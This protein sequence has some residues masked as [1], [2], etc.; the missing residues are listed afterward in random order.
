MRRIQKVKKIK[1]IKRR[2]PPRTKFTVGTSKAE[3]RFGEFLESIGLPIDKQFRIAYKFYDFRIKGKKVI[4]EFDGSYY[5]C[6]PSVYKNGPI[7]K[8]QLEAIH[9]DQYKTA[10]A[11]A[12]GFKVFRVWEN[13]FNKNK[14]AVTH[15]LLK[16]L[17]ENE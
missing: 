11:E 14:V 3:K 13:D 9:N 8:Q 12:N 4:I 15:K 2:K 7:N 5:H 16:F 1:K 6:D 10:L 17:S